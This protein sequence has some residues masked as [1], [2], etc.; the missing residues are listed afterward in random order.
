MASSTRWGLLLLICLGILAPALALAD[1]DVKPGTI[2][3]KQNWTQYKDCFTHGEQRS[4]QGD[5]FW[6]MPEDAENP[7]RRRASLHL[8]QALRGGDREIR[9]AD[10]AGQGA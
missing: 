8:A 3:T 5:L 10:P 9:C 1:C 4:W 2:I 6:K 7:R